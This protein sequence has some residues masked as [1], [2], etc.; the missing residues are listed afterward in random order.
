MRCRCEVFAGGCPVLQR[1][2]GRNSKAC[3]SKEMSDCF[4]T[5]TTLHC[6]GDSL[7]LRLHL[8]HRQNEQAVL[9]LRGHLIRVALEGDLTITR[10]WISN[11]E[12]ALERTVQTLRH[13]IY[14]LIGD[15]LLLSL[16]LDEYSVIFHLDL[17]AILR[18][19]RSVTDGDELC[20][21]LQDHAE[22]RICNLNEVYAHVVS[23][24]SRFFTAR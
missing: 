16:A 18:D 23:I 19:A 22:C 11:R 2:P 6:D 8:G 4:L 13:E 10:N 12:N 3:H 7:L 5:N 15:D 20:W 1:H 17:D 9:E 24:L 21:S 14:V